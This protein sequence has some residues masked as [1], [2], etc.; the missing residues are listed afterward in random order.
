[1]GQVMRDLAKKRGLTLRQLNRLSET[2]PT[3]DRQVDVYQR[4]LGRTK[5]NA[6]VE[7]RTSF[8]FIPH[9]FKVFLAASPSVGAKRIWK[10]LQNKN[11]R[12]E[13]RQVRSLRQ[14]ERLVRQRMRS[15]RKRYRRYYGFDLFLKKHYDLHL[16]TSKLTSQQ[17]LNIVWKSVEPH[18]KRK[19]ISTR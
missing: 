1:M 2:D 17:A 3:F 15:D 8:Y 14:V 4:Q 9:S 19:K 10:D 11:S 18:L 5:K 16:D 12:N 13:G 7:G 6:I